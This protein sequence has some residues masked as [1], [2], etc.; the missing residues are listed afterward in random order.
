M[1]PC[2]AAII[3]KDCLEFWKNKNENGKMCESGKNV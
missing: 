2:P 3:Q 1:A